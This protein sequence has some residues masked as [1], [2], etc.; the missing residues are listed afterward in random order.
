MNADE[1]NSA[2]Q[3]KID[4]AGSLNK[5]LSDCT[6]SEDRGLR[7]VGPHGGL[8]EDMPSPNAFDLLDPQFNA[9]WEAIKTWDI[10]APEYYVGYTGAQGNHVMLILNALR[11]LK[12]QESDAASIPATPEDAS[13]AVLAEADYLKVMAYKETKKWLNGFTYRS[14][15]EVQFHGK[16]LRRQTRELWFIQPREHFSQYTSEGG[17]DFLN[18][19]DEPIALETLNLK[20]HRVICIGDWKRPIGDMQ[21]DPLARLVDPRHFNKPIYTECAKGYDPNAKNE[22]KDIIVSPDVI[23]ESCEAID[24]SSITASIIKRFGA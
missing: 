14:P 7:T 8:K 6:F 20:P 5:Q 1:L 24:I 17:W 11:S 10:N 12:V 21:S 4:D 2:W 9:V 23:P 15:E 19:F 13:Q 16:E 18:R 22:A 3:K